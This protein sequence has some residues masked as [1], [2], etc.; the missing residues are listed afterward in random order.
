MIL[1]VTMCPAIDM[2]MEVPRL[3]IGRTNRAQKVSYAAGGKGVNVSH[4]LSRFKEP[5]EALIVLGGPTADHYLAL[6]K[7]WGFPVHVVRVSGSTRINTVVT[8]QAMHQHTKVDQPGSGMTPQDIQKLKRQLRDLLPRSEYVLFAGS[9][10]PEFP[11]EEFQSLIRIVQRAGVKVCVDTRGRGL[12]AAL[13]EKVFLVKPNLG[14]MEEAVGEPLKPKKSLFLHAR[15]ILDS[16]IENLVVTLGRRG[17][18]WFTKNEGWVSQPP[19][20]SDKPTLA[21]GDSMMAGVLRGLARGE[22]PKQALREGTAMSCAT[23]LSPGTGLATPE[24]FERLLSNT[25]ISSIK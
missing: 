1:T 7:A 14:E 23:A 19:D 17:A 20:V 11:V 16:G 13:K 15:N 21:A 24:E 12:E 10:A 6:T 4:V 3:K 5:T 22:S 2:T 25:E 18:Y 9:L 8:D